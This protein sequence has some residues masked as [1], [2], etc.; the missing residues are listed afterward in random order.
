VPNLSAGKVDD[1]AVTSLLAKAQSDA[2]AALD[3]AK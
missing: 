3:K 1:A 2:Q